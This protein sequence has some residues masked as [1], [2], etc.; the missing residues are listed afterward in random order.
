MS[1]SALTSVNGSSARIAHIVAYASTVSLSLVSTSDVRTCTFS[2]LSES[3]GTLNFPAITDLA[4]G[5]AQFT[6]PVDPLTG[7]GQGYLCQAIVNENTSTQSISTFILGVP[8]ATYGVVPICPQETT[9]RHATLGWL[10]ALVAIAESGGG[11]VPT[12]GDRNVIIGSGT[13]N[14]LRALVGA[15][16][17]LVSNA[18]R[19]AAGPIT[20]SGVAFISRNGTTGVWDTV[21]DSIILNVGWAKI[22]GVPT[23]APIALVY[24]GP[25]TKGTST[26]LA[27]ADHKHALPA[28]PFPVPATSDYGKI[29]TPDFF[30]NGVWA[31]LPPSTLSL[32]KA[33]GDLGGS[34]DTPSVLKIQGAGTPTSPT[35]DKVGY[36]WAVAAAGAYGLY[37]LSGLNIQSTKSTATQLDKQFINQTITTHYTVS[38]AYSNT[39]TTGSPAVIDITR[40]SMSAIYNMPDWPTNGMVKVTTE[41]YETTDVGLNISTISHVAAAML[42]SGNFSD[43]GSTVIYKIPNTTTS[44]VAVTYPDSNTIRVTL[45]QH[46][47]TYSGTVSAR[48]TLEVVTNSAF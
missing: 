5:Q 35:S 6:M 23:D 20:D 25:N 9:E 27:L 42:Y 7:A 43:L 1:A 45:N 15:D 30:T 38:I 29:L 11:V 17:P 47:G 31:L 8:A 14:Q 12:L 26:S 2:I 21:D 16:L 22:E 19:G 40:S 28:W 46:V 37:P 24:G 34:P 13:G 48:I 33:A 36:I 41:F 39:S 32:A 10:L 3:N 18:A 44:S 4:L